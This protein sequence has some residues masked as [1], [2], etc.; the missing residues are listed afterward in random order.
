MRW[1]AVAAVVLVACADDGGGG[2]GDGGPVTDA[3]ASSQ[4]FTCEAGD[5]T[6]PDLDKSCQTPSDCTIAFHVTD[7]CGNSVAVGIHASGQD[8]FFD[9]EQECS[10]LFPA[11]GCPAGQP[12]AEDGN[13]GSPQLISV[14]CLDN[15]CRT[16]VEG[17]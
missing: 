8:A 10:D 6:F 5:V 9:A 12:V 17:S 13:R 2:G 14:D 4:T 3:S 7:C 16:F 11:C 15:L 1:W